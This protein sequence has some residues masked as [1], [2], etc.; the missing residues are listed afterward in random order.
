MRS[1]NLWMKDRYLYTSI[2]LS[3]EI[4]HEVVSRALDMLEKLHTLQL[5]GVACCISC[6]SPHML[7]E[8]VPG[9]SHHSKNRNTRC[10]DASNQKPWSLVSWEFISASDVHWL[11]LSKGTGTE[12]E[13]A[14]K[15]T[16]R[17]REWMIKNN[18]WRMDSR[19]SPGHFYHF[20]FF[21]LRWIWAKGNYHLTYHQ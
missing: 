18:E 6:L 1:Q 12:G 8:S 3:T 15:W 19:C 20:S 16:R 9:S 17:E 11:A 5:L 2:K 21:N 14:S 13:K 7:Q 4:K 10:W